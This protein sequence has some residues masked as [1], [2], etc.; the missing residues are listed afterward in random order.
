ML[1]GEKCQMGVL[2]MKDEVKE[3]DC[4][5]FSENKKLKSMLGYAIDSGWILLLHTILSTFLVF[6]ILIR[7]I[8]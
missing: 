2:G 4:S 5:A 6:H 7:T 8:E 3:K 1:T